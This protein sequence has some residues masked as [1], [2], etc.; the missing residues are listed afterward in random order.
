M[1]G[2]WQYSQDLPQGSLELPYTCIQ[3][4]WQGEGNN[5]HVSVSKLESIYVPINCYIYIYT[6]FFL[7][8]P[9]LCSD[10]NDLSSESVTSASVICRVALKTE[11][12]D[13]NIILLTETQESNSI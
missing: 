5:E 2:P 10:F 3:I 6:H 11:P 9:I 8:G 12:V 4:Y 13:T 1:N 7:H